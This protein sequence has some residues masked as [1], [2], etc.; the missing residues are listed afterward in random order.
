[1]TPSPKSSCLFHQTKVRASAGCE[2]LSLILHFGYRKWHGENHS[3]DL[4]AP[5]HLNANQTKPKVR[6][7]T[8]KIR[9][10]WPK[11]ILNN[12][13]QKWLTLLFPW[14]IKDF[15]Y[16]VR[17]L[18]SAFGVWC[19]GHQLW[20]FV[21]MSLESFLGT[22][23]HCSWL[24]HFD[25]VDKTNIRQCRQTQTEVPF[26]LNCNLILLLISAKL[27]IGRSQR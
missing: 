16:R 19:R 1:M 21:I 17:V 9:L 11:A 12:D 25:E 24:F 2:M 4:V 27:L 20:Y 15:L 13:S 6:Q 3:T 7:K 26:N 22:F 23:F 10:P 18:V 8:S 5:N 14:R